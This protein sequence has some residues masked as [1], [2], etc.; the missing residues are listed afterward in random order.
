MTH[1][2]ELHLENVRCHPM[3]AMALDNSDWVVLA[4]ANGSGKTSVLEGIYY[5]ARGRSFR[6]T[7]SAEAIRIGTSKAR[8]LLRTRNENNHVL[9]MELRTRQRTVHLDGVVADQV[10][11]AR[12][13]PVEYLGGD[14]IQLV[15]GPPAGRRRFMDWALFHVEPRFL[16]VWR[17]WYRAH[18]Q[19]NALL[20]AHAPSA[21]LVPWTEAVIVHGEMVSRLRAHFIERLDSR[22]STI[23]RPSILRGIHLQFC[24]G[25]REATLREALQQ[26]KGREAQ[27]GRAVVGPQQDD[28][29]LVGDVGAVSGLSRGQAKLASLILYRC[30]AG[31]MQAAERHPVLLMD[32]IAADL[33]PVAL[34]AALDLWVGAGLQ[35]WLS[36]LEENIGLDLPGKTARFHVKQGALF[37]VA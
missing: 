35:I 25:W 28:W 29:I 34:R 20:K 13:V 22:L 4:G 18:R 33:D 36:V 3:L 32:D 37:A 19:R 11:I 26:S 7:S 12:A 30:Q 10:A 24:R 8:V 6:S 1:L 14:T 5:A 2:I 27:T 21:E 17:F 16:T 9:G 31:L 15:Q 23:E